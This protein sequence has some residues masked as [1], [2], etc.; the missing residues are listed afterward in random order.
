M[1]DMGTP[2]Q[3]MLDYFMEMGQLTPQQEAIV[4]QRA[5]AQQLRQGAA[6]P[7]GQ[8]VGK[9]YVRSS[10]LQN[11]ASVAS[12]G[13][14]AYKEAG[15]DALQKKLTEDRASAFGR[16]RSRW[17]PGAAGASAAPTIYDEGMIPGQ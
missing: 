12:A 10:P 8:M 1:A 15:A 4:R 5:M 14:G 7:E 16:L 6:P 17:M 13:L 3:A 9:T 2:D 11:L